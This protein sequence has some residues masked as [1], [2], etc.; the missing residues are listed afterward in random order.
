[1]RV[2]S[3]VIYVHPEKHNPMLAGPRLARTGYWRMFDLGFAPA[4]EPETY[5]VILADLGLMGFMVR[6][7]IGR[8]AA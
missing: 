1:M 4:P 8:D 6:R 7:R 3:A 2:D 5:A